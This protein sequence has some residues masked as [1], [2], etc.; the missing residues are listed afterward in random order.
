MGR[1]ARERR[2]LELM[3]GAWCRAHHVRDAALAG[4]AAGECAVAFAP[5]EPCA[6]CRAFL[7]YADARLARCPYGQEKPTCANCPVHC[8]RRE[9]RE[10]AR[11]VMRWAGPR[12]LVRHPL[13]SLLHLADGRR[14]VPPPI[15]W[16][17]VARGGGG[18]HAEPG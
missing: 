10:F 3:V 9:R 11:S 4:A 15:E 13:L 14:R 2:T 16:R 18:G 8:Y 6:E 12:M 7:A 17:R 1:L 5:E